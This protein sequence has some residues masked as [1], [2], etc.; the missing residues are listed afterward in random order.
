MQDDHCWTLADLIFQSVMIRRPIVKIEVLG[1]G[2]TTCN[3]AE[4]VVKDAEER[5]GLDVEVV[6]V[7][8]RLEIARAGVLMT[9]GI[10]LDG[11]IMLVGKIPSVE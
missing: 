1:T 11:R 7:H 6:K 5:S 4:A 8:G 9:P 3:T 10:V 2:C